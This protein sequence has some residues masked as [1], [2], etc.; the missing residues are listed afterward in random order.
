MLH[1]KKSAIKKMEMGI[2]SIHNMLSEVIE[3]QYRASTD[4]I[5]KIINSPVAPNVMIRQLTTSN[6]RLKTIENLR[7]RL[8]T[9]AW[10]YQ[11]GM[12]H[13]NLKMLNDVAK[14]INNLETAANNFSKVA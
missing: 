4:E 9:A 11:E 2:V 8:L 5:K 1:T 6:Q 3:F 13:R 14:Q 12:H 7:E 10:H